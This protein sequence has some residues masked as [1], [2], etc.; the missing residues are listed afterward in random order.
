MSTQHTPGPW[1]VDAY[2]VVGADRRGVCVVE[3]HE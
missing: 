2:L 1:R 3:G